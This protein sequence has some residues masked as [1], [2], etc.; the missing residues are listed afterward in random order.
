MKDENQND[1]NPTPLGIEALETDCTLPSHRLC[2]GC[3]ADL[4]GRRP[5]A[6]YCASSPRSSLPSN[7]PSQP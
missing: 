2:K 1:Q 5:Q 4:T 6:V 7:T 3:G